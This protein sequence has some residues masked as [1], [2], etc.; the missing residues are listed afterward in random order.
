MADLDETTLNQALAGMGQLAGLQKSLRG[1]EDVLSG[2]QQARQM[3]AELDA[4]ISLAKAD[5]LVVTD[6]LSRRR[7]AA[8]KVPEADAALTGKQAE[9]DAAEARMAE[10][11]NEADQIAAANAEASATLADKQARIREIAAKIDALAGED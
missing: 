2:L 7:A 4:Q 5:L 6:E 10:L 1:A 11:R 3:R 8:R 9:I